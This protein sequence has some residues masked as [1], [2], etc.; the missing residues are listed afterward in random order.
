MGVDAST[1]ARWKRGGADPLAVYR[2]QP[3]EAL[4]VTVEGVGRQ[5]GQVAHQL[6]GEV[7][8]GTTWYL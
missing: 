8:H 6:T 2:P 3:A 4:K 1:V 7:E 5:L